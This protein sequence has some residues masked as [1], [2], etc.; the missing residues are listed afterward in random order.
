M[1]YGKIQMKYIIQPT[2]YQLIIWSGWMNYFLG[3]F[4]YDIIPLNHSFVTL[5]CKHSEVNTNSHMWYAENKNQT[6]IFNVG[7]SNGIC[8]IFAIKFVKTLKWNVLPFSKSWRG[9]FSIW[10]SNIIICVHVLYH[11]TGDVLHLLCTN[12]HEQCTKR[13][14]IVFKF[15]FALSISKLTNL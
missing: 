8:F 4:L 3:I 1:S 2:W 12:I 14:F 15:R 11:Y 7:I 10:L 13:I 5:V 9:F 6:I